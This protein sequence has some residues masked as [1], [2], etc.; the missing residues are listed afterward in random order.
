MFLFELLARSVTGYK[1]DEVTPH[2]SNALYL[3][4]TLSEQLS[5]ENP[6]RQIHSPGS[7]HPPPIGP[8]WI[9]TRY[10]QSHGYKNHASWKNNFGIMDVYPPCTY[11]ATC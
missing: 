5:P 7:L 4:L 3:P 2:G 10:M 9:N 8:A 11:A 6:D 1:L